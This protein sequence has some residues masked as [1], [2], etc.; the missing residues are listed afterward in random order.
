MPG[1]TKDNTY[2]RAGIA[3]KSDGKKSGGLSV[4]NVAG[5]TFSELESFVQGDVLTFAF[6]QDNII[7]RIQIYKNGEKVIPSGN[8]QRYLRNCIKDSYWEEKGT[9]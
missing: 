3:W 6:D 9:Y 1:I 5:K 8:C 4:I 7:P 2:G